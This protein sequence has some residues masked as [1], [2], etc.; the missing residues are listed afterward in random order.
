MTT[1]KLAKHA[2][3]LSHFASPTTIVVY[4]REEGESESAAALYIR[5]DNL[6]RTSKTLGGTSSTSCSRNEVQHNVQTFHLF[7]PSIDGLS[8]PR[9]AERFACFLKAAIL[10]Q[11]T[12][13]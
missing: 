13:P 4:R 3:D 5:T 7:W 2:A 1:A 6:T 8:L 10:G 12:R 9:C 11:T